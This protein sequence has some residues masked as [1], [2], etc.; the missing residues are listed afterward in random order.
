MPPSTVLLTQSLPSLYFSAFPTR[1]VAWAIVPLL[2]AVPRV[3]F[4]NVLPLMGAAIILA[5]QGKWGLGSAASGSCRT[6]G[7]HWE[8]CSILDPILQANLLSLNPLELMLQVAYSKAPTPPFP[9]L[10]QKFGFPRSCW[11]ALMGKG[12]VTAGGKR[13]CLLSNIR[14]WQRG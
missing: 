14:C 10:S 11:V 4:V 13:V 12:W 3:E 8:P 7:L 6:I 5:G 2:E 1:A 9:S